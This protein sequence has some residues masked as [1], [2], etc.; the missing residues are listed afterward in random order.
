MRP[1]T[2]EF[3]T[4]SLH[5]A[6]PIWKLEDRRVDDVGNGPWALVGGDDQEVELHVFASLALVDRPD[7]PARL[8][9]LA[10]SRAAQVAHAALDVDPG[11]DA[12]V[13]V[14]RTVGLIE[15]E[16]RMHP[17]ARAT[18]DRERIADLLEP[19]R[20]HVG[21]VRRLGCAEHVDVAQELTAGRRAVGGQRGRSEEHTSELQSPM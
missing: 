18:V 1:A 7:A 10:D 2:I 19:R 20:R 16:G 4:L 3:Y 14:E 11:A 12:H 13:P 9:R 5:D 6:L 21:V 17:G 8:E 15:I